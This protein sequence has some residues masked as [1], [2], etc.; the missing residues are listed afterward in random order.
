MTR[1]FVDASVIIHLDRAGELALLRE[2]VGPIH[3]T[4]EVAVELRGGPNPID[5][6]AP[7]FRGWVTLVPGR[8]KAPPMG[9]GKG[10]S[11][12][13]LAARP[14]DRLVLDDA[15]ARAV[16]EAR[17][18]QHVGLLGLLVAGATSSR[19]KP[20]R[21]LRVLD[22]L[23]ATEFRLPPELYAKARNAIE[24]VR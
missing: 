5:L 20:E 10:E 8:R 18:L 19:L 21:A 14:G 15:Q 4:A 3:V 16:A 22:T 9:L 17:G 23:V 24:S 11:S 7:A 12:L 6:G 13:L 2:L 1:Y